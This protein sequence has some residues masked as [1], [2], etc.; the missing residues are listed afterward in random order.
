MHLASQV[1]PGVPVFFIDT[2]KH[3]A[4]TTDMLARVGR[5]LDVNIKVVRPMSELVRI[6][7]SGARPLHQV[8]PDRCCE[9]RK[10]EPTRRMLSGLDAWVTALR[11]DQG[12][13][14]ANLPA[15]DTLS[16]DQRIVL[17]LNPL[18][19]WS[20]SQVWQHI[21]DNDLPYNRLLDDGY[22]SIGCAPC[23][24]RPTDPNDPRSGRWS[25]RAKTECGLH[26]ML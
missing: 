2:G 21:H 16:I 8:D 18:V 17:K 5:R 23:T 10:V 25:G 15:V 12:A 13:S 22:T 19:Q 14:R 9:I 3:F 7:E 1:R 24:E 20:R 26:T 11:R 6:G 4:Q